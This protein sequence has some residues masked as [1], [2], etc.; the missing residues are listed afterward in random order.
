MSIN[1]EELLDLIQTQL[2]EIK[3]AKVNLHLNNH[4]FLKIEEMI[5]QDEQKVRNMAL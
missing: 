2:K 3:G 4:Q 1:R 5:A